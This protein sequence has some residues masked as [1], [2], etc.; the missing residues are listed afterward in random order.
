MLSCAVCLHPWPLLIHL[1]AKLIDRASGGFVRFRL[2]GVSDLWM[3]P[4]SLAWCFPCFLLRPSFLRTSTTRSSPVDQLWICVP[5]VLG[6]TQPWV[7]EGDCL[8]MYTTR[9]QGPLIQVSEKIP[10][11]T[12][13]HTH[14]HTCTHK[15][16]HLHW[17]AKIDD[18]GWYKRIENNGWRLVSSRVST[19]MLSVCEEV[20]DLRFLIDT[21]TGIHTVHVDTL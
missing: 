5:S 2:G 15:S 11:H 16:A 18:D 7:R 6:I 13:T 12:H 20:P 3:S 17:S 9:S 4:T 10:T 8:E 14:T 1:Q 19:Q 21:C